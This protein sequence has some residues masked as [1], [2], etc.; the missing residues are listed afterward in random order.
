MVLIPVG[1]IGIMNAIY[2]VS[3]SDTDAVK[4]PDPRSPALQCAG[5]SPE[6]EH[7]KPAATRE[8][9]RSALPASAKKPALKLA[10]AQGAIGVTH[11]SL[12]EAT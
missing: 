2:Q 12:L 9:K 1:G 10:I 5:Q 6:R 3:T 11:S 4:L 8:H 7:R